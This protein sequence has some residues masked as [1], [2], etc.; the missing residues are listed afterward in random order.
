MTN[1]NKDEKEKERTGVSEDSLG[2]KENRT[3]WEGGSRP[4]N[5]RNGKK[6]QEKR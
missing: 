4:R 6:N 5:G 1:Q 2:V 3:V